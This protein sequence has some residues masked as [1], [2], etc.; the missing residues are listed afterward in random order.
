MINII[1][2][3]SKTTRTKEI[4][5][6]EDN[7]GDVRL[8][9]EVIR[10]CGLTCNLHIVDDGARAMDFLLHRAGYESAP[11][12]DLILL[13][14]NMPKKDGYDVLA[15]IKSDR[16]LRLIPVIV[17][18]S[19]SSGRDIRS[20]YQLNANCYITKPADIDRYI[21]IMKSIEEFWF[22]TVMLPPQG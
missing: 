10:E 19:S 2:T 1:M 20:A 12:P 14:L 4:L 18:S 7:P 6:A 5:L 13:D 15:A 16:N 3:T 17:L 11:R 9:Q 22:N 8:I 21:M